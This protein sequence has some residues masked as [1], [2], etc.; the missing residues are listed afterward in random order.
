MHLMKKIIALGIGIIILF[1]CKAQ[2][3]RIDTTI[4]LFPNFKIGDIKKYQIIYSANASG[5][6]VESN[7]NSKKNVTIEIVG[8]RDT[9]IDI[10]WKSYESKN[11][12]KKTGSKKEIVIEYTINK[13]GV[14]KSMS[15]YN[16]DIYKFH[17]VYGYSYSINSKTSFEDKL[18]SFPLKNQKNI[19]KLQLSSI[20]EAKSE[21]ILEGEMITVDFAQNEKEIYKERKIKKTY[22]YKYPENWLIEYKSTMG[23]DEELFTVSEL[24]VIRMLK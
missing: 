2:P 22:K 3:S 4:Q 18:F 20:D 6:A 5:K 12:D 7:Y 9:L 16:N 1:G 15:K 8:I 14:I 10:I 21:Y 11:T 19:L 24:Y 13:Q 17:Q 23:S